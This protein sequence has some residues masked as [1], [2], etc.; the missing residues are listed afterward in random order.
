MPHVPLYPDYQ[1][2]EVRR[3]GGGLG[4][5]IRK[6][7]ASEGFLAVPYI[8]FKGSLILKA[9]KGSVENL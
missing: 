1:V 5:T 6:K 3:G 7:G 4:Y 8:W 2:R 9:P